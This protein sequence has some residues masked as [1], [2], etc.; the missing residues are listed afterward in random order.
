MILAGTRDRDINECGCRACWR[1]RVAADPDREPYPSA[2]IVCDKCGNKRCPHATD[3]KL[4]CT[5][6][7]APGQPGSAYE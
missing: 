5:G 6:S 3:H 1:K 2:F 4:S 7:N